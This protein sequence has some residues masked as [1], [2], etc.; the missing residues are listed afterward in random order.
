[1]FCQT[2]TKTN[3]TARDVAVGATHP[4][5]KAT[6]LMNHRY[7]RVLRRMRH[8]TAGLTAIGPNVPMGAAANAAGRDRCLRA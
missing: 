5:H 4:Q 7:V 8:G 2:L 3:V 6:K 1:M